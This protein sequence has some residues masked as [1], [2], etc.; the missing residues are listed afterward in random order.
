MVVRAPELARRGRRITAAWANSVVAQSIAA[1]PLPRCG[2][3]Q[4]GTSGGVI[5]PAPSPFVDPRL[6]AWTP[7]PWGPMW[8]FGVAIDGTTMRVFD[9][10][11]RRAG[12]IYTCDQADIEVEDD[13]HFVGWSFD[14]ASNV[15]SIDTST[16]A[17]RPEDADGLVRGPLYTV[18]YQAAD[19]DA[20]AAV[21]L[22]HV[23]HNG[24]VSLFEPED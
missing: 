24:M 13:N 7:F 19:G 3:G 16:H 5:P 6:A 4:H 15:L 12:R 20:P 14:P 8:P 17:V 23:W 10:A 2:S 22:Q 21:W 11:L 1:R 18:R 9:G